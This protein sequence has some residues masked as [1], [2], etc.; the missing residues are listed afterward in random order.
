MPEM[1]ADRRYD[2][3]SLQLE[4]KSA[5]A[6]IE[7]WAIKHDLWFDCGFK[8]YL[9]HV[10]A[11]PNGKAPVAFI[12]YFS[13]T[14]ENVIYGE[15]EGEFTDLLD[16]HGFWYENADGTN[17]YFYPAD[18]PRR[19]AYANYFHWEWICH[20]VQPDL[21]D[22]YEELY[23]HFARRP[24]DLQ[25]LGW[26]EFEILLARIFQTQGFTTELGPGRG[27]G[28]IDIKLLQR[29][30]IGDVLTLVQVKKYAARN[31]IGLEAVAA[32]SG[33]AGVEGA[34]RSLFVTTSS[35][36]PVAKRFAARTSGALKLYTSADVAQ[37]C[38]A[39]CNGII[40]DKSSLVSPGAVEQLIR[41]IGQHTDPRVV[42]AHAGY[43]MVLN[44][45]ALVLRETKHAALLMALPRTIVSDDGYG[46]RGIEIPSL[47]ETALPMLN[48]ACVWRA[49]RKVDPSGVVRYWDGRNLYCAWDGTPAYFDHCD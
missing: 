30:P 43:N 41:T 10:D 49:K 14:F 42:H 8:S 11:E 47:D 29:D 1:L 28:G 16:T 31:K 25:R 12:M 13:S 44:S 6:S 24:V 39:A 32:L 37:W 5:Q 23:A 19:A 40:E 45:F 18:G 48:A 46:Q 38:Q 33:I 2:D 22:V 35:Y 4:I 9:D 17:L 3:L 26:R 15:L 34:Q 36:L 7:A 20:L 27:D 21:A